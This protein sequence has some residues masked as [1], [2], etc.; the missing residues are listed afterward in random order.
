MN[1]EV[2][3]KVRIRN[4]LK[5]GEMYGPLV[6][7]KIM[8]RFSGEEVTIDEVFANGIYYLKEDMLDYYSLLYQ[9]VRCMWTDEMIEGKAEVE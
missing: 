2:G 1:Y 4:D 5:V 6:F 3:D 7:G 9:G 8:H